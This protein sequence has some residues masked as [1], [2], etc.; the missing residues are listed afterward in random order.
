MKKLLMAVAAFGM[1][2]TSCAKDD[3]VAP[4]EDK[5]ALVSFCV[6][7]PAVATRYGEGETAQDLYY[8]VY[9]TQE[10]YVAGLSKV[11]GSVEI[12]TSTT[13]NLNL[14][15]GR[16]Y[17]V[18]FWAQAEAEDAPYT[19]AW[20]NTAAEATMTYKP[21]ATLTAN[22]EAYDAFYAHVESFEVKGAVSQTV[23]LKRPF[24][25]LNV[26]T[27][28]TALAST[29]GVDIA[30][31]GVE[32]KGVYTTLNLAND[33]VDGETTLTFAPTTKAN[34]KISANGKEYDHIAMNYLLVNAKKL[35][36]VTLT[37][38]ENNNTAALTRNYTSV[39]VQRNYRTNIIGN[40]LT[41]TADFNVE[42]KPGF[43]DED[44]PFTGADAL[45]LAAIEGGEYTLEEDIV[46][47]GP[48]AVP[49][50][51]KFELNLN[52][53]K[54]TA[55]NEKGEG[56]IIENAGTL[57]ITGGTLENATENGDAVIN[58]TGELVLSDVEIKGAPIGTTGYPDY[59]I[60]NYG[61]LTIEEGTVVSSDRGAL[62]LQDG[63]DVTINGGEFVVT[64]AVGTRTLTAHV[65]YAY[66]YSSKLTINGG[67]FAMN[68]ANGGGTSVICP[69]GATIKV[70]GG[71]FYH[72]PVADVQSGCFQNYMGYGAPVD[73]YGGTFND[74]TVTKSGNLADGYKAV[75]ADGKYVVV[76]ESVGEFTAVT[77]STTD[78]ATAIAT[79]NGEKTMFEWE[80]VYYVAE[81]EK[82]SIY[83]AT[84]AAI[85]VR[86]IVESSAIKEATIAEGVTV[87]GNRTFR[88]CG[89]L[90][91]VVLPSSL[92]EIGPAVF[93]SCG[94]LS[95]IVLP[96]SVQTIGEGAFA[97]CVSLSSIN[98]PAGVTR[99]EKDALRNTGL[100]SVEFPES[101]TYFG[102]YA[103]RDCEQLSEVIINAPSFTVENNTFTNMAAPVP[104]ITIKV[105][106]EEMKAY[107]ESVLTSYD[108]S[109]ITVVVM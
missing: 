71:N 61:K 32:V 58:N 86:G 96:A 109:Y 54:I 80:D 23:E 101:V 85:T 40:I 106:N 56:A 68:I 91:T 81:Y 66:G 10:G 92:T 6:N 89:D 25:Q 93:Q 104:T 83:P 12:K 20:G 30:T 44:V 28:D 88:K 51:V 41:S 108:K 97:E 90:E 77:E 87:V 9:D 102:T 43:V 13:V 84:D 63:A 36:D 3:T 8:A 2:L 26:A 107:L 50:G 18:I 16:S 64:D 60:Y 82:V 74:D 17:E 67:S 7:S 75:N 94:K 72:A 31:T 5:E 99:I 39:P 35:V 42:I 1:L 70:Y 57:S 34:G 59:A 49:A 62:N 46:A 73:V 53:K 65:I 22:N 52:G 38:A 48:I 21:Q 24:A 79:S 4:V 15:Q 11:D 98:I 27:A 103:L 29:A 105:V 78:F 14:V 19:L 55:N 33:T 45:R 100:V 37:L 76:P 47:D 69:A 95:S